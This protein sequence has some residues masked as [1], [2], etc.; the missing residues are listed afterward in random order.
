M[1]K[2]CCNIEIIGVELELSP[3]EIAAC[4]VDLV[5]TVKVGTCWVST[6]LVEQWSGN[7]QAGELL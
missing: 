3:E 5:I 1:L 6:P 7:I 4:R 2:C